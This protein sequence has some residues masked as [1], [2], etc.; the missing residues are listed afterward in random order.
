MII[1]SRKDIG[2]NDELFRILD[3]APCPIPLRCIED[4]IFS[5]IFIKGKLIIL[6]DDPHMIPFILSSVP[7]HIDFL[8]LIFYLPVVVYINFIRLSSILILRV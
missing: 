7:Y 2:N 3:E 5:F 4:P 6:L 8:I 1:M